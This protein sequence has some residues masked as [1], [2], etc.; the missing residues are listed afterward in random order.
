MKRSG[1]DSD[2]VVIKRKSKEQR[3][4]VVIFLFVVLC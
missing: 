1:W 4:V 2:K 3:K